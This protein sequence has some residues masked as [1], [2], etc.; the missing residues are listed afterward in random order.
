MVEA[1]LFSS[2]PYHRRTWL[3]GR[4]PFSMVGLSPEG[5]DCEAADGQHEWYNHDNRLSACY[6]CRTMREG[7]LW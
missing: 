7:Q 2:K 5:S 4:L 6:H 1:S 3:R